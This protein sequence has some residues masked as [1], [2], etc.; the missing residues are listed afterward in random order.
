MERTMYCFIVLHPFTAY[1]GIIKVFKPLQVFTSSFLSPLSIKHARYD[2]LP[3]VKE[4]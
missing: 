4:I 2:V 3:G 1:Q